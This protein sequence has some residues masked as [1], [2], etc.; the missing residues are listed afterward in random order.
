MATEAQ[1]EL[2]RA[3]KAH[4]SDLEITRG[5]SALDQEILDRRIEAARQLSDWLSRALEPPPAAFPD[6]DGVEALRQ[7]VDGLASREAIEDWLATARKDWVSP[8]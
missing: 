3:L 1:V 7:T 2:Y 6:G 8:L 4:T 5:V